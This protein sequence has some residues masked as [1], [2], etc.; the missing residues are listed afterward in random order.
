MIHIV[1]PVVIFGLKFYLANTEKLSS[2]TQSLP[3][4]PRLNSNRARHGVNKEPTKAKT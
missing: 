4:S 2:E 1:L 3:K